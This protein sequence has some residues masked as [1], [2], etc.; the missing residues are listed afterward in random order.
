MDYEE[1]HFK[2]LKVKDDKI[3]INSNNKVAENT[4]EDQIKKLRITLTPL[5]ENIEKIEELESVPEC[6]LRDEIYKHLE[7]YRNKNFKAE[8][9]A[10]NV[11][12]TERNNSQFISFVLSSHN[13]NHKS[14]WSGEWLSSWELDYNP[15]SKQCSLKGFVKANTYY[16]EEGNIQFNL[17]TDFDE[18]VSFESNEEK[19][20]KDLANLVKTREDKIQIELDKV[21]ENFS[22]NY[23]KPL[24][25]KLPITGTKMNWNLNQIGIK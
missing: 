9:S 6:R 15:T 19:F 5:S 16:Y 12:F 22:E 18:K 21:Y 8:T 14:F 3:V 10:I 1:T 23:V 24:R 17:K 20:A 13:V 4:Y 25:R 7:E 2:H 11:H